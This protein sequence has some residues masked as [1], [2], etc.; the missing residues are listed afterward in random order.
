MD[1]QTGNIFMRITPNK[2]GGKLRKSKGKSKGKDNNKNSIISNT[3]AATVS[4][5]SCAEYD[6]P[7]KNPNLGRIMPKVGDDVIIIVKPYKNFTCIN[8]KVQ[9][10]LTRRPV[11][12]RGH[13]VMIENNVVGRTLKIVG[14]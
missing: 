3:P 11:H 1:Y 14:K 7:R 2:I 4:R 9:R 8:G 12:T 13:K 5:I 10:V 6:D